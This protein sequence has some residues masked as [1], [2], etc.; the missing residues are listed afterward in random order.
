RT[1]V[2]PR[3]DAVI[4]CRMGRAARAGQWRKGRA[5]WD[6]ISGAMNA[7]WDVE[8][9]NIIGSVAR[10]SILESDGSPPLRAVVNILS[11]IEGARR[12]RR[13]ECQ[14]FLAVSA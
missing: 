2:G 7:R 6:E 8:L 10:T 13:L 14:R 5:R 9:H 4:R 11:D 12:Q 3:K 1:G